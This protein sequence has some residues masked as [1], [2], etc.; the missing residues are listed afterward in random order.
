MTHSSYKNRKATCQV[1][2]KRFTKQFVKEY[3]VALQE[4]FVYELLRPFG[5]LVPIKDNIIPRLLYKKGI[6]DQFITGYDG[7]VNG[8]NSIA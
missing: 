8:A 6:V 7:F 2:L 4:T 1:I 3:L 5:D